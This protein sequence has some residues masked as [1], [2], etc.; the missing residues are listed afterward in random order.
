[1]ILICSAWDEETKYLDLGND[2]EILNLGIGYLNAALKLE[3]YLKSSE[4][5]IERIVF[6][7]TAGLIAYNEQKFEM[8][9]S[10]IYSIKKVSLGD[11]LSKL[12]YSYVPVEYKV[13]E[14]ESFNDLE[15]PLS[16]AV[17]FSNLEITKSPKLSEKIL[18]EYPSQTLV[19]NMELY[20]IAAIAADHKTPL[21]SFLVTT[22]YTN[23]FAHEDWKANHKEASKNLCDYVSKLCF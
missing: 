16:K 14:I 8:D 2:V 6:I 5:P 1:M 3:R 18:E 11:Y 12:D 10:K 21:S 4:K 23:F 13:H 7:G 20:G 19:E 9:D 17:A 15:D 22:N